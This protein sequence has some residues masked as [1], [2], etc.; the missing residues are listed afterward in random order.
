MALKDFLHFP[1]SGASMFH[2]RSGL[3]VGGFYAPAPSPALLS[4]LT[5][6]PGA[7][8]EAV[9]SSPPTSCRIACPGHSDQGGFCLAKTPAKFAPGAASWPVSLHLVSVEVIFHIAGVQILNCSASE[10]PF[11]SSNQFFGFT[12]HLNFSGLNPPP[13]IGG[14][15]VRPTACV[16]VRLWSLFGGVETIAL[17]PRHNPKLLVSKRL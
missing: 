2:M 6:A 3:S 16:V 14:S 9:Q 10:S 17:P 5:T 12:N 8:R 7:T 13:P 1:A 11:L 15:S 4:A